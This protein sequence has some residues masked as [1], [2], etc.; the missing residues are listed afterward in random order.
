MNKVKTFLNR[1]VCFILVSFMLMGNISFIPINADDAYPNLTKTS[2][3]Y[4]GSDVYQGT[5]SYPS[6]L[7]ETKDNTSVFYY[8]DG[9]FTK[10]STEYNEHLSSMSLAMAMSACSSN[11]GNT[12]NPKDYLYKAQNIK[13]LMVD[14]GVSDSDVYLSDT[15]TQKMTNTTIAY[16]I[17]FKTLSDGTILMPI[18]IRGTGYQ[19]EWY[20]NFS[21]GASGEHEGFAK[22]ATEVYAGITNYINENNIEKDKV[23]FWIVG[24]SRS[25]ATANLTAKRLIDN[26]STDKV[27]AYTFGTPKG[28]VEEAKQAGKDYSSIHNIINAA[29]VI[30]LMGPGDMGFIRYGVDHYVPGS[31]NTSTTTTSNTTWSI[32]SS[33]ITS[34]NETL[35]NTIWK[36][37]SSEYASQ[38]EKMLKQLQSIDTD[39]VKAFNDAGEFK[40]SSLNIFG[41]VT[42]GSLYSEIKDADLTLEDY[43]ILLLRSIESLGLYNDSSN[44]TNS[45]LRETFTNDTSSGVSSISAGEALKVFT[46]YYKALDDN[47]YNRIKNSFEGVTDRFDY[48]D[49]FMLY[50]KAMAWNAISTEDKTSTLNDLWDKLVDYKGGASLE[51]KES[52]LEV[53]LETLG[54]S[55]G[56]EEKEAATIELK[57]SFNT[58]FDFLLRVVCV[59]NATYASQKETPN[60]SKVEYTDSTGKQVTI[61][62]TND[63]DSTFTYE[64]YKF[65]QAIIAGS[66]AKNYSF[67]G[68]NHYPEL[69]FAWV[70]SYDDYYN[71]APSAEAEKVDDLKVT[72]TASSP[73][74]EEKDCYYGDTSLTL[75]SNYN[76]AIILYRLYTDENNKGSYKLYRGSLDLHVGDIYYLDTKAIYLNDTYEDSSEYNVTYAP[77][78]INSEDVTDEVYKNSGTDSVAYLNAYD[79][80]N[81]YSSSNYKF[82]KWDKYT[83]TDSNNEQK[84]VS[85]NSTAK[86]LT[87]DATFNYA[88][89]Y[90]AKYA[91]LITDVDVTFESNSTTPTVTLTKYN[92]TT[93]IKD[94][95]NYSVA[96]RL[97]DETHMSVIMT[98][99]ETNEIYFSN[100]TKGN[101][102]D[103]HTNTYKNQGD[104]VV[105]YDEGVL[106]LTKQFEYEESAIGDNFYKVAVNYVDA[107]APETALSTETFVMTKTADGQD[108]LPI[109]IS[110]KKIENKKFSSWYDSD[111][112]EITSETTGYTLNNESITFKPSADSTMYAY[113]KPLV[114]SVSGNITKLKAGELLPTSITDG[115]AKL[116]GSDATQSITGTITW[117]KY[118][119]NGWESIGDLT[120]YKAEENK[121]Y[122]ATITPALPEGTS[123]Q[124]AFDDSLTATIN[125]NSL[126]NIDI[127]LVDGKPT[128][129]YIMTTREAIEEDK[130][131]MEVY[132]PSSIKVNRSDD[133]VSS[134]KSALTSSDNP[135]TTKVL[136]ADGTTVDTKVTFSN[137][138]LNSITFDSTNKN[139]Q[140]IS[141]VGN[142][143]YADNPNEVN[144]KVTIRVVVP[145]LERM[146][147]PTAS[148][149]S[150]TYNKPISVTLSSSQSGTIYYTTDGSDPVT[151]DT[152]KK[153]EGETVEFTYSGKVS[154]NTGRLEP[155]VLSMY[156][157]ASDDNHRDSEVVSY[158][159]TITK[160][161]DSNNN[162]KND[163]N[164]SNTSS[165]TTDTSDQSNVVFYAG[166][167]FMAIMT[168]GVLLIYRKKHS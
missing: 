88:R 137:E 15:Y 70:R 90:I 154:E 102:T 46:S 89:N 114:E 128:M 18:A 36:T 149:E 66:L 85:I 152:R 3:T 20:S 41:A 155:Y 30:S 166:L 1:L 47:Q 151:S 54:D 127:T 68:L 12:S 16:A 75:T 125:N 101:I 160:G 27:Y 44:V 7:D 29:D 167:G 136:L 87:V 57:E 96:Y 107:N 92:E 108:Q 138:A 40:A 60:L 58:V 50:I 115:V 42:G 4:N 140:I 148:V 144:T 25:A 158:T 21:L 98:L 81:T 116:K 52:V 121:G 146:A 56:T 13:K 126:S 164:S 163:N 91:P 33:T 133:V 63:L 93:A 73:Y 28:G 157:L 103:K 61:N 35:D 31:T 19:S 97:D 153:Y 5:F 48:T 104:T 86:S 76:G 72:V 26:Y 120:T 9:Y 109:T 118:G 17:G 119:E 95:T 77:I 80:Y 143:V 139:D 8:S 14:I 161:D 112:S 132:N 34:A 135:I 94:F 130:S 71:E 113:Y 131:L 79:A 53:L 129:K 39:V 38:K 117:E 2:N 83:Y 122:R 67:L 99:N 45:K 141:I 162:K 84:D 11:V 55:A 51:V 43:L 111:K 82:I 74:N 59:D 100:G 159:Y 62:L 150:N 10:S 6:V 124:Y 123:L 147:N 145:G 37:N 69:T 32:G 65:S 23:K 142:V 22:A 49:L 105:T 106:T 168:M 64:K 165:K 134:I 24:Y 110:A 156:V 78:S